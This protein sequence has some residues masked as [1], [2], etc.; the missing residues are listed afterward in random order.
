M[1]TPLLV[2]LLS[3]RLC[4]VNSF[5]PLTFSSVLSLLIVHLRA[6]KWQRCETAEDQKGTG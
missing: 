3:I 4:H 6:D 5:F 2:V 1:L